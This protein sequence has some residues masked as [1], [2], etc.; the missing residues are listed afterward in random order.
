MSLI[1]PHRRE[2]LAL[3][4]ESI[5]SALTRSAYQPFPT[6]DL[7]AE[8]LKPA[9]SFVTLR[10]DAALRGCCGSIEVNR[11][12]AEDVWR[13]AWAA[14]FSDPRFP[15]LT[16]REWTQVDL[17]ISV[18]TPT[19]PLPAASE[20]DLLSQLR[21]HIDGLILE[22]GASRTTFLPAVWEQLPDAAQFLQQLKLK[23]GWAADFW[24]PQIRALRYRTESFGEWEEEA[25]PFS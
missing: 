17:H 14:A 1:E 22:L 4:R 2:L 21:P 3:A 7:P 16:Y 25:S 6:T 15:P 20:A 18:L 10:I 9:S 8:L 24:S 5:A 13:A 23:A 11:S 19:E 12:L